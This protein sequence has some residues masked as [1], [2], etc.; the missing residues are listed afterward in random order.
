MRLY[1]RL[2]GATA[3]LAIATSASAQ[4]TPADS[5][6]PPMQFPGW[7]LDL[8][9]LDT[10]VKPGD[11]FDAF[12][13]G[14]WKAVN[15]IPAKYPYYGVVTNLRIGAERSVRAIIDDLAA[16]QNAAGSSEQRVADMYRAYQNFSAINAAGM[17][18][19]KPYLDKINGVG[20]YDALADLWATTGYP[21]PMGEFVSIDRGAPTRNTL[22]V[23]ITGIGLPDR[24]NYLVD[25]ERYREMRA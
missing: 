21:S 23:A 25:N 12:V 2:L 3:A 24:D 8:G 17:S 22:F 14:K 1:Q 15:E 20:S 10:S 13:N 9:D 18:A 16:K 7:G 4:T 5:E 19:S 6:P 11:D